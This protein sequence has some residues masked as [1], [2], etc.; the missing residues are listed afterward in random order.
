MP[1]TIQ[2]SVT[3]IFAPRK[4][5]SAASSSIA[6]IEIIRGSN[7]NPVDEVIQGARGRNASAKAII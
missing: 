3:P 1:T 7:A 6:G 4:R 2:S 5:T